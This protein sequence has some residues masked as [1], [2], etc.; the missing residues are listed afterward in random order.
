M[1]PAGRVLMA[2]FGRS[3]AWVAM[4]FQHERLN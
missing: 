1:T 3:P 2:L 4:Q